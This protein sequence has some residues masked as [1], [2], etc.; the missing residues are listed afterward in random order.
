MQN[1]KHVNISNHLLVYQIYYKKIKSQIIE[2]SYYEV[3]STSIR[4]KKY[5][6]QARC[7]NKRNCYWDIANGANSHLFAT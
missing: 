5:I 7:C 2:F 6:N 4:T 3:G 1:N